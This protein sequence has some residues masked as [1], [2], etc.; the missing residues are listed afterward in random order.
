M[1]RRDGVV[2]YRVVSA[3]AVPYPS[4]QNVCSGLTA[5]ASTTF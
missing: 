1:D 5:A 2:R 4:K 3:L